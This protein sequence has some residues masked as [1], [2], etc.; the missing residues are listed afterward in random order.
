MDTVRW[1]LGVVSYLNA[2]VL[3]E[4]LS[5]RQDV[6]LHTAVPAELPG[7]LLEGRVDAA[8][9]P[10]IDYLR[11]REELVI[12]SDACIGADGP[13]MTVRVYSPVPPESVKVLR[14]DRESHTSVVLAQVLWSGCHQRKVAVKTLQRGQQVGDGEAVLLIGDKVVTSPWRE[15][16]Y[17]IDL[18]K[19]WKQWTGLPFVFAVWAAR[20]CTQSEGLPELLSKARDRGVA[21]AERIARAHAAAHGWDEERAVGYL[22]GNIKYTLGPQ[23]VAGMHL[24]FELA[25][26]M[27]L[28]SKADLA[29]RS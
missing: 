24:F 2:R 14:A 19:L 11:H 18:G 1:K 13:T 22:T 8:I 28:A 10:V 27:G 6:E 3:V 26:E 4:G 9:I 12:V 17:D 25:T 15:V 7:L 23:Y 16:A 29:C 21:E 5:G 20:R